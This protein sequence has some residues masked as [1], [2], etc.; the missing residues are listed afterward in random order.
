MVQFS[1]SSYVFTGLDLI[2]KPLINFIWENLKNRSDW[3]YRYIYNYID[4]KYYRGNVPM[5]GKYKH[6]LKLEVL[7]CFNIIEGNP[8]LFKKVID[9]ED[10]RSLRPIR[11]TR[12]VVAHAREVINNETAD[13]ALSK[14]ATIMGKIDSECSKKLLLLRKEFYEQIYNN[15]EIVASKDEL[16]NFLKESI[17]D[18][19]ISRL[20]DSQACDA[21]LRKELNNKW[22]GAYD[23]VSAFETAEEVE[24]WFRKHLYSKEGIKMYDELKSIKDI[25]L[26]T[27]EDNREAFMQLCYGE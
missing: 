6:I 18:V 1:P 20:K 10:I 16:V 19:S 23:E 15:K 24:Q 17:W 12:N 21:D 26:P 14:M 13:N 8:E 27:F 11:K 9:I 3:W 5:V 22:R 2:R 4:K 7:D 25:D